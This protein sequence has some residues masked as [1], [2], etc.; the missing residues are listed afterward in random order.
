MKWEQDVKAKTI[1]P[2]L[3]SV[4]NQQHVWKPML[5]NSDRPVSNTDVMF[6]SVRNYHE[7]GFV[8]ENPNRMMAIGV[9]SRE[10]DRK[11]SKMKTK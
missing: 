8:V 4:G 7:N 3:N 1:F 10:V 6:G 11:N 9:N 2:T 5:A